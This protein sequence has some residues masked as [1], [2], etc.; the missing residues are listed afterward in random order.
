MKQTKKY[1]DKQAPYMGKQARP[2]ELSF[3]L[4]FY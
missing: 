3:R 1:V 4:A 2:E